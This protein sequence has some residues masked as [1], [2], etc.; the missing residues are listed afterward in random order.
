MSNR[1]R[2]KGGGVATSGHRSARPTHGCWWCLLLLPTELPVVVLLV[3]VALLK[4]RA[5]RH[6]APLTFGRR[7]PAAAPR[8]AAGRRP[9]GRRDAARAAPLPWHVSPGVGSSRRSAAARL[10]PAVMRGRGAQ[11]QRRV[12]DLRDVR[13]LAGGSCPWGLPRLTPTP[14]V[15]RFTGAG[16]QA[17]GVGEQKEEEEEEEDQWMQFGPVRV[18]KAVE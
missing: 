16:A 17:A 13:P 11:K 18:E 1:G 12:R 5:A 2:K 10:G 15:G 7:G 9:A 6:T 14:S 4:G 8:C 3:A